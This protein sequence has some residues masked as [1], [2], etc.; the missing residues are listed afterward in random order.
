[1]LMI[2]LFSRVWL[3]AGAVALSSIAALVTSAPASAEAL[4]SKVADVN[5]QLNFGD[6]DRVCC[7]RGNRDWWS[8]WR[9][10]RR[11]GGRATANRAC[12]DNRVGYRADQRVCCQ[13]GRHDWWST[14]R[15]CRR[16]DGEPTANRECRNDRDNRVYSLNRYDNDGW[17][18]NGNGSG[19]YELQDPYGNPDRR[20]CCNSRNGVTWASWRECR[21]V[22]GEDVANKS[23]RN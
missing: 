19:G 15:E 2:S 6:N 5:V 22:G 1:M 21:R 8:N 9:E 11:T 12:N 3:F 16:N 7:K 18:N 17:G 20:V 13:R 4:Y 10:C 14:W 23:C